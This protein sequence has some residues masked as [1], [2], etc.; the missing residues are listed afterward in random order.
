[1]RGGTGNVPSRSAPSD[2]ASRVRDIEMRGVIER[3]NCR[4]SVLYYLENYVWTVDE[5]ERDESVKK[6]FHGDNVI[7]PI[8]LQ[9]VRVL[10]GGEDDYL[11]Y[12]ALLWA[13]QPLLA[14][15]KS[16]QMRLSHLMMALHGWLAQFHSNQRI[17]IQSK[18]FEDADA[19][20]ERRW[21][22]MLEERKRYP[23]IPW[24]GARRKN[25]SIIFD[26]GS[27]IMAAAQ[28]AD[29]VR[30]YTFSAIFSDEM[31]FQDQA[32]DAY[33]AAIPTIEGGG[34]FTAVSTAEISFF[35]QLVFD[36]AAA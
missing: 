22:A 26:H 12:I 34:K 6:L 17:A 20:L 19:L 29:I 28:G 5:H 2:I 33:T 24:A 15:P 1:M 21:K 16:R 3:E 25:G 11:R 13:E 32:E 31:A 4:R 9:P 18:K 8:S 35:Q 36:K 10:D 7:E 14:V 23:H 30:S 27:I